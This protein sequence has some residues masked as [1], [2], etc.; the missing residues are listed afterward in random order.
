MR[1]WWVNQNQTFEQETTGGYLWSPKR[2]ANGARNPFYESMREVSPGDLIFSFKDTYIPAIGIA[3]SY[4][5]EC[6]KPA[7]F[8]KAGANWQLIGWKVDVSYQKINQLVRPRDHMEILQPLLPA[9]YS[10]LQAT[11]RGNQGV[12][13]TEL[14][15]ELSDTLVK[16]IGVETQK[17]LDMNR[18]AEAEIPYRQQKDELSDWE[19]HIKS[20]LEADTEIPETERKALVKS[21]VGQGRF[22]LNVA[23]IERQCRITKVDRIEHLRA[24]HLKPWRDSSNS[25]RLD[26]ENGLLLTP[27]IDHLFDRGFIS[28]EDNG[29]LIISPVA[30]TPSLEKMGVPVSEKLNVGAFIEGQKQYLDFHR[31]NVFL[32][33]R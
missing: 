33:K 30:H 24:S 27:T 25:E 16:L 17:L 2:N 32:E 6:P 12:Y 3:Q 10:P 1:F 18:V 11:G 14:P 9:Q 19:D 5:Y 22:K 26:G 7:E 4:C 23:Q 15:L 8:G 29:L 13:L 31:E 28:F 21:R 20:E